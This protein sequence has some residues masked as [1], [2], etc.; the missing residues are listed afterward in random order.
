[1]T[2]R[3]PIDA[4]A[5]R[6]IAQSLLGT[7]GRKRFSP[8]PR[9]RTPLEEAPRS[10]CS[11]QTLHTRKHRGRMLAFS[12]RGEC[13]TGWLWSRHVEG[14]VKAVRALRR[15]RRSEVDP[16]LT[17]TNDRARP[18]L[19]RDKVESVPAHRS[20]DATGPAGKLVWP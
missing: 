9:S 5:R 4:E 18:L 19:L 2:Q 3:A 12:T 15:D 13:R 11:D 10:G 6:V 16:K 7:R 20:P 8:V 1:M 14:Y 17:A